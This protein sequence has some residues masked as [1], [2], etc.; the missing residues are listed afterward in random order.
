M[1]VEIIKDKD[2]HPIGW[3]MEGENREEMDKLIDIRNLQFFG[4]NSTNIVYNGRKGG[5]NKEFNP[6]VLSWIQ[7]RFTKKIKL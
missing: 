5:N 7:E 3:T 2:N 1:K 6:G 4:F